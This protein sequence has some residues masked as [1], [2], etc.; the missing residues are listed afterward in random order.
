M[1]HKSVDGFA[2]RGRSGAVKIRMRQFTHKFTMPAKDLRTFGLVALLLAL[3]TL[4]ANAYFLNRAARSLEEAFREADRVRRVMALNDNVLALLLD[5]ETSQRGFLLIGR[6]EYLEPY[7]TAVRNLPGVIAQLAAAV[8]GR[9]EASRDISEL[10][11]LVTD[12]LQELSQTVDLR[13]S[14]KV[15][16]AIAMVLS[17]RARQLMDRIRQI[18]QD[19]QAGESAR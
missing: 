14:G 19:L 7:Q 1:N 10:R 12:K 11:Q 16:P 9:Q 2:H 6:Q 4:L 15:E 18:S 3:A 13:R 17:G 8:S 5:A